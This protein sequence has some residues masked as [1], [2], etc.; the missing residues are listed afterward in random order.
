MAKKNKEGKNKISFSSK[1]IFFILLFILSWSCFV[2]FDIYPDTIFFLHILTFLSLFLISFNSFKFNINKKNLFIFFFIFVNF[3]T[4]FYS[5]NFYLSFLRFLKIINYFLILFLFLKYI[6]RS[7]IKYFLI[8]L[9]L[10]SFWVA[11]IGLYQYFF[12]FKNLN[13]FT[14][15][16]NESKLNDL[17]NCI[18][19]DKRLFSVFPLPSIL[20]S[21]LMLS[22]PII[23]SLLFVV[24]KKIKILLGGILGIILASFFLTF[25]IGGLI[26]FIISFLVFLLFSKARLRFIFILI[27]ILLIGSIFIYRS[28]YL[29]SSQGPLFLRLENWKSSLKMI[30]D[31]PLGFGLNTYAVVYPKYKT[32]LGNETKYAHNS[33]LQIL[34]ETGILGFISFSLLI[35]MYLKNLINRISDLEKKEKIITI[36]IFTSIIAF[37]IHNLVDFNFYVDNLTLIWFYL[38]GISLN[39]TKKEEK[40]QLKEKKNIK[41]IM[42][43]LIFIV[44]FFLIRLYLAELYFNQA[45]KEF[46]VNID[47]AVLKYQK[48]IKLVPINY[49]YYAFI[50]Y[51]YL[52]KKELYNALSAYKK[53]IKLN[54]FCAHLYYDLSKV[55]FLLNLKK[56]EIYNL[57]KA[58]FYYPYK[59]KYHI[60]L[61]K[62]Y[63]KSKKIKN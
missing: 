40:L 59:L 15:I 57:K 30:K 55:Y 11:V 56:E 32:L 31:K 38:I 3:C 29:M 5:V 27:L 42:C 13:Q 14:F 45:N 62:A 53:A 25:S 48:A 49:K 47:Y 24:S 20:A 12:I 37:L 54:P 35:I 16:E 50:G 7:Q 28:N 36:G 61:K 44:L 18:I 9:I 58:I 8:T 51:A 52:F 46:S 34:A 1:I 17:I 19:Q 6:K 10:S 23:F 43:F 60:A 26:S 22:I 4:L 2:S 33:Y 41:T 21:F 39:F 63:E